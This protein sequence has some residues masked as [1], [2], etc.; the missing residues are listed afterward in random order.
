MSCSSRTATNRGMLMKEIRSLI[1][2]KDIVVADD[3][4]VR[5]KMGDIQELA[6]SIQKIGLI[7]P[8]VVREGGPDKDGNRKYTLV[9]G[10]RR[11]RALALLGVTTVEVKIKKI[12]QDEA[13]DINLAENEERKDLEPLERAARYKFL[14]EHSKLTQAQLAKKIGKSEAFVS[15]TLT[16][17]RNLDPSVQKAIENKEITP[18][19]ARE[20]ST[21][22]KAQQVEVLTEANEKKAKRGKAASLS[23][24]KDSIEEKKAKNGKS[25]KGG[26]PT[27][28]YDH[29]KIKVAREAYK[30]LELTPRPKQALLEAM[31]ALV[32]RLDNPNL[33]D[34][35]K[36]VVKAQI[37]TLEFVLGQRER[38]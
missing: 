27:V 24:L 5:K 14:M 38:P 12:N 19:I 34:E 35:K 30:D 7:Q 20:I 1:P 32:A 16:L 22:S 17:L 28:E 11:Y 15:Q 10:E 6:D 36:P 31:G 2:Y 8:L 13:L 26:R 33:S 4:N 37:A 21:L 3:F 18:T 25:K 23:E 9:S 29:E